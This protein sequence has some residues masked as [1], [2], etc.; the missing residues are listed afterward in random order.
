[1]LNIL[2]NWT[3]DCIGFVKGS[4][5]LQLFLSKWRSDP[6]IYLDNP[7]EITQIIH[8]SVERFS[9]ECRK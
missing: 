2:K 3:K 5:N 6:C 8:V 7:V 1:M 4:N 9:F